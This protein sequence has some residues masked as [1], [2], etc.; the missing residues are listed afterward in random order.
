MSSF[1]YN[2]LKSDE[3]D[4]IRQRIRKLEKS[5]TQKR[6][7][8]QG[9]VNNIASTNNQNSTQVTTV[10][11]Y[12][13]L[14][15]NPGNFDK[16][17]LDKKELAELNKFLVDI[18]EDYYVDL[19]LPK[20]DSINN[21][22]FCETFINNIYDKI[23]EFI[24]NKY[25]TKQRLIDSCKDQNQPNLL[26]FILGS[27]E[28]L[29]L[30]S[31]VDSSGKATCKHHQF[32]IWGQSGVGKTTLLKT[33]ATAFNSINPESEDIK[34]MKIE[35]SKVGTENV[36]EPVEFYFGPMKL[37]FR[38]VPGT[39]DYDESR[40]ES[41]IVEEIKKT[42]DSVDSILFAVSVGSS[43]RP[44]QH[45]G[46]ASTLRALAYA[47]ASEG[48]RIWE[49]I[50]ICFTKMNAFE[51][52]DNREPIYDSSFD[53]EQTKEFVEEYNDYLETYSEQFDERV[54]F[55]KKGFKDLWLSLFDLDIYRGNNF[56]KADKEELFS[57]IKFINCGNVT[58]RR[59]STENPF[60]GSTVNSIPNHNRILIEDKT[61][62]TKESLDLLVG[63]NNRI[64]NGEF[65]K[66][67][68]WINDLFNAIMTCSSSDFKIRCANANFRYLRDKEEGIELRNEEAQRE[69]IDQ[70]FVL[71]EEARRAL[72]RGAKETFENVNGNGQSFA[73][74]I[75]AAAGATLCG[76]L[77]F[78][79]GPPGWVV[80]LTMLAGGSVGAYVGSEFNK[81]N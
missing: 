79:A 23:P 51:T 70:G 34:N 61:S 31:S 8:V 54:R 48:V 11:S 36:S 62:L 19:A 6:K 10:S 49:R 13:S 35:N 46:D 45:K 77:A 24:K 33:F 15:C 72:G 71:E 41:K 30:F 63:L 57:K 18:S 66:H 43:C 80:F 1:D 78:A 44:M 67:K 28:L 22:E 81:K 73:E 47:F 5:F 21:D 25:I 32:L 55:A 14:F 75:G 12:N 7:A 53:Y 64:V 29:E 42:K 50:I 3:P 16:N 26:K 56:S 4:T 37:T 60:V 27:F 17:I 68:N 69:R 76:A 20:S 2:L 40:S 9:I 65:V 39:E 59:N 52:V 38:D 74:F 58:R